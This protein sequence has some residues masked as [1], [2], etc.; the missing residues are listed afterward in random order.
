MIAPMAVR[1][2]LVTAL[3]G[4]PELV[5]QM[6]GE[7]ERIRGYEDIYPQNTNLPV[8]IQGMVPPS[9]LVAYQAWG[10]AESGGGQPMGH[11]L[12]IYVKPATGSSYSD[13]T[14]LLVNG[15][16]AGQPLPLITATIHS[17]LDP[18]RVEGEC[19]REVD[20]DGVEYWTLNVSFIE[21]WG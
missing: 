4:L 11:R 10:P 13:L 19:G 1:D 8:A 21:K 16:P 9:I 5:L 6:Q 3:R 18:M 20:A 12:T 2:A 14:A 17:D 15:I 7:A